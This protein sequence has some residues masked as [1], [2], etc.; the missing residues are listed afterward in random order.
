VTLLYAPATTAI[1][2]IVSLYFAAA[3]NAPVGT[4]NFIAAGT[5]T[6]SNSQGVRP[7]P[8]EFTV[9]VITTNILDQ[10]QSP[11]ATITAPA[12][13]HD[14]VG[15]EE[16]LY[17]QVQPS[18]AQPY[19]S[20]LSWSVPYSTDTIDESFVDGYVQS[21]SSAS[22]TSISTTNNPLHFY[23]ISPYNGPGQV[24]FAAQSG[25]AGT[26]FHATANMI[27]DAPTVSITTTGG[28]TNIGTIASSLSP[29]LTAGFTNENDSGDGM[30]WNATFSSSS[31]YVHGQVGMTQL[32]GANVWSDPS[33]APGATAPPEVYQSTSGEYGLDFAPQFGQVNLDE[34]KG[35]DTA[36]LSANGTALWHSADDPS[37]SLGSCLDARYVE[38]F[39]QDYFNFTPDAKA[40]YSTVTVTVGYLEW[41]W[42]AW[43]SRP[44][45]ESDNTVADW[46]TPNVWVQP[47]ASAAEPSTQ[48]PLWDMQAQAA[49]GTSPC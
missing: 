33:P 16:S 49:L 15:A 20:S 35:T 3:A 40:G 42:E 23:P 41:N 47:S 39:F 32:V 24:S 28:T 34:S 11:P 26:A 8:G 43:A 13:L 12:T 19:M 6:N 18:S 36:A 31:G 44:D 22:F 7:G 37:I 1:G 4:Y 17:A 10:T 14:Q 38:D 48:L 9:A 21:Q 27:I 45:N 25:T 2:D 46:G 5:C 30:T 29:E